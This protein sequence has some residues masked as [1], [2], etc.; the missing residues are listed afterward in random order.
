MADAHQ[1]IAARNGEDFFRTIERGVRRER[2]WLNRIARFDLQG[3][4][5][6]DDDLFGDRADPEF[7]A[8]RGEIGTAGSRHVDL[9]DAR[10]IRR[11][12]DF[13]AIH[14]AVGDE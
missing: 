5:A 4:C 10:M 8:V 11:G 7:G 3:C 2:H 14:G 6:N 13:D 9:R 1:A 12:K